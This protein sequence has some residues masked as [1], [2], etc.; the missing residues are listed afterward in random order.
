MTDALWGALHLVDEWSTTYS[1]IV[2]WAAARHGGYDIDWDAGAGESWIRLFVGDRWIA[3]LHTSVPIAIATSDFAETFP[4]P[5]QLVELPGE[6]TEQSVWFTPFE[7][8]SNSWEHHLKQFEGLLE[9]VEP[10]S[11]SDLYV[12]TI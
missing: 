8:P 5:V 10:F 7:N 9:L 6:M 1:S 12:A 4:F 11:A 2:A 3:M